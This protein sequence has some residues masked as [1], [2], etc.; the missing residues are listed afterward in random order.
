MCVRMY[1]TNNIKSYL[2]DFLTVKFSVTELK[3][4]I[5]V[6]YFYASLN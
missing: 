3:I 1:T 2:V 4:F 6:P 5:N